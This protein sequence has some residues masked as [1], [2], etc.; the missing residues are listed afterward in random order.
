MPC[1]FTWLCRGRLPLLLLLL[2]RVVA[3]VEAAGGSA[4]DAVMAGIMAGDATDDGA[5]DA[6]FGIGGRGRSQHE[7]CGGDGCERFHGSMSPDAVSAFQ[8]ARARRGSI[9]VRPHGVVR[10]YKASRAMQPNAV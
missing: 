7:K 1:P 10:S 4:E 9:S 3:A 2:F 6:A 5:L 8:R